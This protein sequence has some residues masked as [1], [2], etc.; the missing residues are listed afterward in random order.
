MT[1]LQREPF[2]FLAFLFLVF[3]SFIGPLRELEAQSLPVET[4][5]KIRAI[6]DSPKLKD[7]QVGLSILDL[8]TV[9][10][11]NAFPAT[12]SVGKRFRILFEHDAQKKF[13][14]AS[15]MKLFTAAIALHLLGKEKTFATTLVAQGQ[16]EGSIL[17]GPLRIVGHGDPSLTY[18]DLETFTEAAFNHGI[19]E[20]KGGVIGDGTMFGAETLGG[21]YPFGWTLDDAIWYYAPEISALALNRNQLDVTILGSRP[22][23][24]NAEVRVEGPL[25][26][27]VSNNVVVGDPTLAKLSEDEL[28]RWDY[29]TKLEPTLVING[30]IAPGQKIEQG[31]SIPNPPKF[32]A[33]VFAE[34]V[35]K[36]TVVSTDYLDFL[37]ATEQQTVLA[38]HHSAPLKVLMQRFLKNSD[39]LYAEMLLR[40]AAYYHDGTGGTKAGP[41]AH[42][43]LKQWLIAQNI[44]I[45]SLRFEDGSGLSRYNLLT[46]RATA[47]LLAAINRMKDGDVIWNALPIAGTD[48]TLRRR[49]GSAPVLGNVRAKTGTFSIASNLSGYVTTQNN[50]RLAVALYIN[51][52]RDTTTAQQ[53]QDEIFEILANSQ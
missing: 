8:G 44:D 36:K 6:L 48:G 27:P 38:E 13:M 7:A 2:R 51:F 47:E 52:A 3:L 25:P 50:R 4:E 15:N 34:H 49:M 9:K 35:L 24:E 28:I 45:S 31:V 43:L 1:K 32:I 5:A 11:A 46:P 33:H 37:V 18:E 26:I 39:N 53:A 29:F 41:R 12:T 30:S 40:D 16:I 42:A 10:D 17:N 19:T 20:V 23:G 14:P 22:Q 21:R